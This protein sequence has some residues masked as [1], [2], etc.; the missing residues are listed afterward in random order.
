MPAQAPQGKGTEDDLVMRLTPLFFRAF[1]DFFALRV[2]DHE[3]TP[4]S[5]ERSA[6]RASLCDIRGAQ[7]VQEKEKAICLELGNRDRLQIT[8]G[9]Q[10]WIPQAGGAAR[11]NAGALHKRR[12]G[13]GGLPRVGKKIGLGILLLAVGTGCTRR[14]R[15][16]R[17]RQN[18]LFVTIKDVIIPFAAPSHR[19]ASM[20]HTSPT[21][22]P[23]KF[24]L[25]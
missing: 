18:Q 11:G 14:R 9:H 1:V 25:A 20:L 12:G 22:D 3:S 10:T 2:L 13:R 24:R 5:T 23:D 6:A 8:H 19:E 21:S 7:D 4:L 17:F 15:V 16:R